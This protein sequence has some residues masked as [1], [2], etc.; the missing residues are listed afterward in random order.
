MWQTWMT[1]VRGVIARSMRS[2]RSSWDGGGTGKPISFSTMPSRHRHGEADL[3]QHDAFAAL[4][5]VP[6]REHPR[7][8]LIGGQHL[9]APLQRDAELDDLERLARVAR[10]RHLLRVAAEAR[11]EAAAHRLEL[12]LQHL[13][14]GVHGGGVGI[15]EI[16]AHRL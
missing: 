14:H 13:P 11:R 12:R 8:V 15:L 2:A 5:L 1:L 9:V 10:D 7:V 6:R 4:S 16:A 3:L